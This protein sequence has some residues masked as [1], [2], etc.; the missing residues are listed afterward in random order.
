[1]RP[2]FTKT[3]SQKT[4]L[5]LY[6]FFVYYD[7]ILPY[8]GMIQKLSD[9]NFHTFALI[10]SHS[11]VTPIE[12]LSAAV[13]SKNYGFNFL[14]KTALTIQIKF[15]S[16]IAHYSINNVCGAF[17]VC[18]CIF[19]FQ[20]KVLIQKLLIAVWIYILPKIVIEKY[21]ITKNWR[22]FKFY[23]LI[24]LKISLSFSVF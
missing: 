22:M 19:Y 9:T 18:L 1:M 8:L 21:L 16:D 17:A 23:K 11:E 13:K 24:F 3:A 10:P 2:L 7:L 20:K 12:F 14:I 6:H 4:I 5:W 15:G